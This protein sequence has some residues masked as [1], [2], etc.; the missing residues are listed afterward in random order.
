MP[1]RTLTDR[2]IRSL[3]PA[4]PGKRYDKMDAVVPGLGVRVTDKGDKDIQPGCTISRHPRKSENGTT[5]PDAPGAG[6]IRRAGPRTGPGQGP[7]MARPDRQGNRPAARKRSASGSPSSASA[8]T[9][10]PAWPRTS[11][12]TSYRASAGAGMPKPTSAAISFRRGVHVPSP[13]SR[14]MT[15]GPSSRP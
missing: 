13:R 1:K 14:H 3:K 11:S 6:R 9:V 2:G 10:S 15:C 5:K 7:R 12:G 8:Q 4:E